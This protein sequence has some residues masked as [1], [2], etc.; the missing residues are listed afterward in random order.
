MPAVLWKGSVALIE[1]PNSPE[2]TQG[3]SITVIRTWKG[4]HS[5]CVASAPYRGALGT[6]VSA[7]YRVAEARVARERGGIGIPLK[8]LAEL[9]GRLEPKLAELIPPPLEER[10]AS[11][12]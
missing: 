12:N 9:A 4:P 11:R 2:H 8:D 6:G 3:E 1:Q 5:T 10:Q 7:G